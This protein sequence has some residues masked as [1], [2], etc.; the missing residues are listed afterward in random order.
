MTLISAVKEII[1]EM[2]K[3]QQ[4]LRKTSPTHKL[5]KGDEIVI[6]SAIATTENALDKMK[7]ELEAGTVS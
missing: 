7:K 1:S 5:D 2:I 3:I 4:V 6:S